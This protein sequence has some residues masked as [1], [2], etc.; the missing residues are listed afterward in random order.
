MMPPSSLTVPEA[1]YCVFS[2]PHDMLGP[3][4]KDRGLSPANWFS[5]SKKGHAPF[6]KL[7]RPLM[8]LRVA[9]SRGTLGA[10][11]P[12]ASVVSRKTLEPTSFE[13]SK[14]PK[15]WVNPT[16]GAPACPRFVLMITTPF[17][18]FWP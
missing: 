18:A 9:V 10:N 11:A 17:D 13:R 8:S 3:D 4:S 7:H 6:G 12:N 5:R 15:R 14:N 1:K 2:V 16:W